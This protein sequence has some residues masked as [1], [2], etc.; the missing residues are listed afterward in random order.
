MRIGSNVLIGA[1]F[2]LDDSRAKFDCKMNLF[3]D[4]QSENHGDLWQNIACFYF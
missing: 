4:F 1:I 2:P 3:M